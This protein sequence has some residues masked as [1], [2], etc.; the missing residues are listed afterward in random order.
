M[1]IVTLH[2]LV[3]CSI[4]SITRCNQAVRGERDPLL[5]IGEGSSGHIFISYLVDRGELFSWNILFRLARDE[6]ASRQQGLSVIHLPV[7]RIKM[8]IQGRLACLC[9]LYVVKKSTAP[10]RL[11]QQRCQAIKTY[12]IFSQLIQRSTNGF[13]FSYIPW[14]PMLI[15][16]IIF[17]ISLANSY[18]VYTAGR[19][20]NC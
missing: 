12:L 4:Q 14:Q 8:G 7:L 9:Q 1:N 3:Q 2:I 16:A 13:L 20:P 19:K 18:T 15:L 11:S 17:L 6:Q 10:L 5:V